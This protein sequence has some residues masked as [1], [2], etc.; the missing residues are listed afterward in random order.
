MRRLCATQSRWSL[1]ILCILG[2]AVIWSASSVLVQVVYETDFRRPIFL[3]WVANSLFICTFPLKAAFVLAR[4]LLDRCSARRDVQSVE[5]ARASD[6]DEPGPSATPSAHFILRL[7]GV[8]SGTELRRAARDGALVAPIWFAANCAYNISLSLTSITSSTVISSSSAAFTLILSVLWLHERPTAWKLIGVACCWLGN[9]LTVAADRGR[10]PNATAIDA[11]S[12]GGLDAVPPP[13]TSAVG[14]LVCLAG[15]ALYAWYT[16]LIRRLAPADLSLFFGFLG[17]W[18]CLALGPV[19]GAL[20]AARVEPLDQLTPAVLGLIVAKGLLDNVLSEYLWANAVML[21]SPSVATVGLSLTVPLAIA[22]DVVLPS[23]WL[24]DPQDP[25]ALS[26]LAAAAVVAGF[27]TISYASAGAPG[28]QNEP[29]RGGSSS[30]TLTR[31]LGM[32]MRVPLLRGRP[33]M[34]PADVVEDARAMPPTSTPFTH[35]S[36][37]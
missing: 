24:V 31:C 1:G 2:V 26:F 33:T 21:T 7:L 5:I 14:D 9:G 20:H 10:A 29:P 11:S 4:R 27:V 34:E 6:P 35:G 30:G 8:S 22:S 23:A 25:T 3:T 37:G 13:G 19:V 15:A 17:L 36:T 28:E 18:T 16:V 12:S 32:G